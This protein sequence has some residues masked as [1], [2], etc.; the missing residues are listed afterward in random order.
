MAKVTEQQLAQQKVLKELQESYERDYNWLTDE[1]RN[2]A[3][4]ALSQQKTLFVSPSQEAALF[5]VYAMGR[6]VTQI[7]RQSGHLPETIVCSLLKYNWCMRM[8]M[9]NQQADGSVLE[10]FGKEAIDTIFTMTKIAIENDLKKI[11]A[12]DMS[13][14]DSAFVPK[15]IKEM[16]EF[17]GVVGE[18]HKIDAFMRLGA[19][20]PLVNVSNQTLTLTNGQAQTQTQVTDAQT[21][22]LLETSEK[23]IEAL[24]ALEEE[25]KE[26]T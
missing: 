21:V 7:A 11:L 12:G 8:Q 15:N 22:E 24:K 2:I 20:Q 13:A 18:V 6:T 14:A 4:R 3:E 17:L 1:E 26:K 25:S 9:A 5:G 16:K 23:R 19:K 10:V